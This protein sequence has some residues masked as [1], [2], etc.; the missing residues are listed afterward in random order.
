MTEVREKVVISK[1]ATV[2]IYLYLKGKEFVDAALDM[3]IE[4]DRVGNEFYT[5]PTYNYAIKEGAKI[6]IYNIDFEDMHG[7]GT[8]EDLNNYINAM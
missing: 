2:G 3:I 7:L 4:N 1:Y 8:P 5:C 6:G